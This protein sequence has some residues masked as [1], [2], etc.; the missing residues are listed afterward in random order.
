MLDLWSR[1]RVNPG[2][3]QQGVGLKSVVWDTDPSGTTA[4]GVVDRRFQALGQL[5]VLRKPAKLVKRPFAAGA[6]KWSVYADPQT[7]FK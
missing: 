1:E 2:T 3:S 5:R 6:L 7:V 4:L